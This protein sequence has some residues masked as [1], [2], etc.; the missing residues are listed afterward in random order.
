MANQ[1]RKLYMALK[2]DTWRKANP[3]SSD[4][5]LVQDLLFDPFATDAQRKEQLDHW[6]QGVGN[7]PCLFGRIA[8]ANDRIHYCI[9]LEED[10][11][12]RSDKEIAKK[13]EESLLDWKRR[14]VRPKPNLSTPAF[15]FVLIAASSKLASAAPDE[16]LYAFSTKLLKLWGAAKTHEK[17]SGDMNWETLYLQNPDTKEYYRF[18]FS[19]DFFS[20]QGDKR[21]WHDHRSPGGLMYTA[22]SV[23]HMK[24]Y[25]EWYEGRKSQ[26]DWVLEVAMLTIANSADPGYGKATWLRGLDAGKP[27]VEELAC[28]F[29][30]PAKIKKQLVDKDWTKYGG[31]IHTDQAIR[32]YFFHPE[33]DASKD[34][35]SKVYLE[36]FTYL[37]DKNLQDNQ[38]FVQG[39]K[40]SQEEIEEKIGTINTW[41]YLHET[42]QTI[43]KFGGATKAEKAKHR[44]RIGAL[45]KKG[46]KWRLSKKER[47][48]ISL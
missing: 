6:L 30:N 21:W 44:K 40:V 14:S 10:F 47:A 2:S 46:R 9:L 29:S 11:L 12:T 36:D 16:H 43:L 28:P 35:K 3:F 18:T 24:R 7:Q 15:G 33:A 8:A 34:I 37:Y 13:I 31:W 25:R 23:G 19:V 17:V 48:K 42:P 27:A 4:I 26:E 20:A 22:N 38:R 39:E 41:Q 45:L 5:K 32:P 1:L